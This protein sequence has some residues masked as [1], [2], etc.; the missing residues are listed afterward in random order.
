MITEVKRAVLFTL[1]T[2]MLFGGAYH[3]VVW[4]FA[5]A[6]FPAK[7]SG[8]L[9]RDGQGKMVGSSLV[10]QAFTR[11]EYFHPRPSA[12]DYNADAAGGSNYG[13]TNPDHL[14]AVRER[15]AAIAKGESVDI[16]AIPSEMV[17]ASGAG[18][19]PDIP[20]SGAD[21]QVARVA[22]ARKVDESAVRAIVAAAVREP[23]L[24]IFGRERVNVLELNLELDAHL[25]RAAR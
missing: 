13:P 8:S 19:D 24:G 23:L 2:M 5:T 9:V 4:A 21:I 11:D 3:G 22:R 20:P 10:A 1:T 17:T 18:L 15:A 12:V 16:G 7:A 25:G 14:D 6:L